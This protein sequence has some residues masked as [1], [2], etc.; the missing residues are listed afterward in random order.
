MSIDAAVRVDQAGPLMLSTAAAA[1]RTGRVLNTSVLPV[2]SCMEKLSLV[3][4]LVRR[5]LLKLSILLCHDRVVTVMEIQLAI[6]T[7]TKHLIS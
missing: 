7:L 2:P 1:I 4:F 3:V 5:R 6:V